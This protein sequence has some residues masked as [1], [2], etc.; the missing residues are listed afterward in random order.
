MLA[1]WFPVFQRI[2]VPSFTESSIPRRILTQI[3]VSIGTG[4]C[5]IVSKYVV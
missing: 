1:E 3:T 5:T 2:L 4:T